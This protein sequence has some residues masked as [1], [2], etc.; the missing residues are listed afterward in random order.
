[1]STPAALGEALRSGRADDGLRRLYG[2]S[3]LA[4]Q[5]KR[6]LQLSATAQEQEL[7]GNCLLVSAPGRTELGG[8]HTDHNNGRVLAAAVDLDCVAI[9]AP[10]DEPVVYLS[11]SDYPET[12]RVELKELAPLPAERA[13]PLVLI[14]GTAAAR[15]N[16]C[17]QKAGQRTRPIGG[18]SGVVH[19]TCRPGTG[20]SSSAAFTL[21]V[22]TIFSLLYDD[23]LPNPV[24]L[25]GDAQYAENNYFGKPCGLMDQLSSAVGST[26]AIDFKNPQQPVISRINSNFEDSGYR[27]LLIDTGASHVEL[28]ADYAAVP[29]EIAR[30]TRILGTDKARGLRLQ[31]LVPRLAELRRQAGDRALLRL[32]H[33]I[34][35]DQRA[36]RQAESLGTADFKTY[37]ELVRASGRSSCELLQNCSTPAD[38]HEQGILLAIALTDHYFPGAV[39][40]VHGG[41]FAGTVQAY[42]DQAAAADYIL[43]MERVF[44]SGSVLP[45]RIGRPGLCWFDGSNWSFS[46]NPDGSP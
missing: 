28:T 33:F 43:F 30:C 7:G 37:L 9:A 31:D 45:V 40:R 23:E 26:L 11:S 5:K 2:T 20:L 22:G 4:F 18:F 46:D 3:A 13:R 6:Y 24:Q 44:G 36:A 12:I 41:G 14:R 35:E 15:A 19:S 38:S 25:A 8:N 27:L 10:L 34:A 39:C 32:I 16:S 1:M 21:T 17:R 29:E 42:I